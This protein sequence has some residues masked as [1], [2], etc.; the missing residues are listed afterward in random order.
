MREGYSAEQIRAAEAP[1]LA[2][3]E[4]LM[5]RAAAALADVVR[6]VLRARDADPG[7]VLLLVGSGDNGGDAL[8]AGATLAREGCAVSIIETVDRTHPEGLAAARGA[9][10]V[11]VT[12]PVGAA[13]SVDVI[14]DGTLGTGSAASPALRGRARDIVAALRERPCRAAVVAVDLPSGIQPDD[15]SVPDPTVLPA[16]IT[17]TFGGYKAGLL[18]GRGAELAGDVRL[19]DIGIG[20]ELAGMTPIV[21]VQ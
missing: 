9:G 11:S 4:P 20:D 6:E 12:E 5:A 13:A 17:V 21:E 8:F 19:V 7:R 3:G 15:G 2:A 18:R 16:D 10:A 14:V 1:H